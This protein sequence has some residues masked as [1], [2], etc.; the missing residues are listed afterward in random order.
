MDSAVIN[1][2]AGTMQGPNKQKLRDLILN[3]THTLSSDCCEDGTSCD[4][5]K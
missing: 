3:L 1:I 2:N 5:K 4:D